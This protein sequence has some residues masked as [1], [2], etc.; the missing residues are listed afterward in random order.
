MARS[1]ARLSVSIW[2]DPDFLA[3][4]PGA[5]RMFMFLLSQP[6]LAHDGVIALRERRWSK[7]AATLT[8]EQVARDLEELRVARFVVI[9]PDAE[10][11]L[12][13]SFIRRDKV[14]RQPNVLRAACDHLAVVSSPVILEAL[15]EELCRVAAEEGLTEASAEIVAAMLKAIEKASQIPT[16]KGLPKGSENPSAGTPGERGVVTAVSSDSPFPVPLDPRPTPSASGA[17]KPRANRGARIPDDFAITHEMAEWAR[18]NVPRLAGRR[19]TEKFVNYWQSK[20]GKDATKVDWVKTWKNWMITAA[21]RL[22]SNA[23]AVRASSPEQAEAPGTPA[24]FTRAME[25]A[26]AREGISQ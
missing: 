2:T 19:E 18:E 3:L 23:V 7:A 15:A 20:A 14:Y 10:E 9:D 26:R 11:L 25:R 6:D 13:R 24:H 21:E 17:R 22:P 5:Q 1:E 12:I 4:T 16:E 8:P